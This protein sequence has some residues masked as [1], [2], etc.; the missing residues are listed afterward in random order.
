MKHIK[1]TNSG[2]FFLTGISVLSIT[3]IF[4]T[5]SSSG[6]TLIPSASADTLRYQLVWSDEF[7]GAAVDTTAW[8]FDTGN[9]GW[10]NNELE[11]YKEANASVANGNLIITAKKEAAGTA[12]YTSARI[13]TEGK[14][15]FTFGRIEARIKLPSGQGFWPAFW[16]LGSSIKTVGWPQCG[17]IDIMEHINT[18]SLLYGTAHW[19]NN[20]H[21]SSG[22]KTIIAPT[23]YHVYDIEW[24]ASSIT[25]HIDGVPYF[26]TSIAAN[27]NNTGAFHAPFFILFNLAVGG[28]WPGSVVDESKFP[29][30]M[31]VDYVRVYQLK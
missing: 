7:N 2:T 8:V 14:K 10:G 11:F 16:T 17:E 1:L 19:N 4:C 6:T 12:Q 18:D 21:V 9:S 25:W 20:G 27:V 22:G 28:N 23:G 29:A 26:K 5:K 24:N 15:A 3:F 30:S 31:Y 13:K